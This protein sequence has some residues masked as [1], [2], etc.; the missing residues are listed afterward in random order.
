MQYTQATL[1]AP[2]PAGRLVRLA[3]GALFR[4]TGTTWE[5]VNMGYVEEEYKK[6][7]AK[8]AVKYAAFLLGAV[9][10]IAI[11]YWVY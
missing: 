3:D 1:P 8:K 10:L 5:E 2:G 9:L 11:L 7:A 6:P 4:D